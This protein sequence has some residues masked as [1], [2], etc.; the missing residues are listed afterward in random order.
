MDMESFILANVSLDIEIENN[1]SIETFILN[2]VDLDDFLD[3]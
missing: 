3:K 1:A 2:D